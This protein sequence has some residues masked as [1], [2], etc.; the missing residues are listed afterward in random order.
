MSLPL[1]PRRVSET[2][3]SKELGLRVEAVP[4]A[5]DGT[6]SPP[7]MAG[8]AINNAMAIASNRTSGRARSE[9]ADT[10][11]PS[12]NDFADVVYYGRTGVSRYDHAAKRPRAAD[13]VVSQ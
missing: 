7:A 8:W 9:P 12:G 10:E 5:A 11:P 1:R 3:S 2:T 13:H 4:T 6:T